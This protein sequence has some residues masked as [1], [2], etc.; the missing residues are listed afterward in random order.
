MTAHASTFLSRLHQ[1]DELLIVDLLVLVLKLFHLGADYRGFRKHG[2]QRRLL[3]ARQ[4]PINLHHLH[5]ELSEGALVERCMPIF[6]VLDS[7]NGNPP[8]LFISHLLCVS[9]LLGFCQLLR[10]LVPSAKHFLCLA[11]ERSQLILLLVKELVGAECMLVVQRLTQI[12]Q[13]LR[14][15]AIDDRVGEHIDK[16]DTSDEAQWTFTVRHESLLLQLVCLAF[17]NHL[18]CFSLPEASYTRR[19]VCELVVLLDLRQHIFRLLLRH[20]CRKLA[21]MTI[22]K[23]AKLNELPAGS[24]K[25]LKVLLENAQKFDATPKLLV[26]SH[27]FELAF[28]DL[29]ADFTTEVEVA[30]HKVLEVTARPVD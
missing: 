11:R 16:E 6:D 1:L 3:F 29:L 19:V 25:L 8:L 9:S 13:H 15:D 14:G 26:R 2:R 22:G 4:Q 28:G 21:D 7:F 27:L 20:T 5:D 24:H 23:Q 17:L 12:M 10:L 30:A 18:S